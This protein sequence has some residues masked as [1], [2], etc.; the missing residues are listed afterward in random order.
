MQILFQIL[1][2]SLKLKILEIFLPNGLKSL[3]GGIIMPFFSLFIFFFIVGLS[4]VYYD[5]RNKY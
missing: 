4:Y 2:S 5:Y 1:N 3:K